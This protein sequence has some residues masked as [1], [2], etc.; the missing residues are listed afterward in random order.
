MSLGAIRAIVPERETVTCVLLDRTALQVVSGTA[1]SRYVLRVR[2]QAVTPKL[3][4]LLPRRKKVVGSGTGLGLS[5][6]RTRKL[7]ERLL[8]QPSKKL[9]SQ[10]P[11]TD[12]CQMAPP[13][14]SPTSQ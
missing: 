11:L 2:L 13:C 4:R 7:S 14:A 8:L 10:M 9:G 3:T 5:A 6:P 12:A 1:G